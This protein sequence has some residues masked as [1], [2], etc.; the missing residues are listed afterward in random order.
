MNNIYFNQLTP[1]RVIKNISNSSRKLRKRKKWSQ[2]DLAE[3]SGVSLGSVKRFEGT[4]EISLKSLVKIA[5]SLGMEKEL[6]NLFT[7]IP[8]NSIKEIIDGKY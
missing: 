6:N 1:D 4:G 7:D 3:K 5:I 8:P 2:V